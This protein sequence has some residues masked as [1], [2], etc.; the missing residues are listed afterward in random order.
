MVVVGSFFDPLVG[1]T[2]S[3]A[4]GSGPGPPGRKWSF[5]PGDARFPLG[6]T[7]LY[8]VK[9]RNKI[10]ASFLLLFERKYITE[11]NGH[12]VACE[13]SKLLSQSLY[14]LPLI[15]VLPI[16]CINTLT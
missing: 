1:H 5:V 13:M 15:I 10:S 2:S 16:Y 14:L 6:Q 4:S 9:R 3:L 12:I 8:Q 7:K 11:S